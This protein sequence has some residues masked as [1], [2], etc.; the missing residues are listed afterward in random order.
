MEQTPA[1]K[2]IW[3]TSGVIAFIIVLATY[4]KDVSMDIDY[5]EGSID[6]SHQP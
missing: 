6:D 1:K 3:I 2:K 4:V 5:A